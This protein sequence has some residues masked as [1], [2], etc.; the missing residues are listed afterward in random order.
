MS[1]HLLRVL[2]A[3]SLQLIARRVLQ[4][5]RGD[6]FGNDRVIV[7]RTILGP[8]IRAL[9]AG[10]PALREAAAI[11]LAAAFAM[12]VAAL[13]TV[14]IT[15]RG[16]AVAT[17]RSTITTLVTA[18]P[19]VAI[20][21]RGSTI[22]TLITALTTVAITTRGTAVATRRSTITTL[23]AALTAVSITTRGTAV[24]TR[25]AGAP[26]RR[27]AIRAWPPRAVSRAVVVVASRSALVVVRHVLILSTLLLTQNGHPALGGHFD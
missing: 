22:T 12:L 20:T 16:T 10:T 26:G 7:T 11:T 17:R 23:V 6:L 4:I 24:A 5:L 2:L 13:P 9:T 8:T 27:R 25:G 21:S 18:L 14:A 1:R 3:Q 15:T 19:T